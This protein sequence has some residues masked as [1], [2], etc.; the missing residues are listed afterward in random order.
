MAYKYRLAWLA[1]LA[2]NVAQVFSSVQDMEFTF[3]LPAGSKECF[4]QTIDEDNSLEFEYQV[5]GQANQDVSFVMISPSG[6][7]EFDDKRTNHAVHKVEHTDKG[8]YQLCFDNSYSKL[9]EKLLFFT[10]LITDNVNVE[11][12]W[13]DAIITNDTLE[14]KLIDFKTRLDA[15]HLKIQRGR[16]IQLMLRTFDTRDQ[17]LQDNNLWRVSFWS[18]ISVCV[19]IG[20]AVA[21]VNILQSLFP[22]S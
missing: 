4:Y 2:I 12:D 16:V 11:E 9:K 15:L 7:R 13:A 17:L 21:Q 5:I 6:R 8:D 14:D 10:L 1:F 20:V 3:L 18:V 22:E 19:I